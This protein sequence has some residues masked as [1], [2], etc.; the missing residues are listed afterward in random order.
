VTASDTAR[1][2][3]LEFEPGMPILTSNSRLSR[4]PKAAL[5]KD[6]GNRA[7][8][9]AAE[10]RLPCIEYADV[11]VQY[12]PPPRRLRDRHPFASERVEDSGALAPTGKAL[13]DGLTQAGV[14]GANG[15]KSDSRKHVRRELYELLPG[16]HPR[17]Q[18]TVRITEIPREVAR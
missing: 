7:F 18:V 11:L 4:Y 1:T 17:G 8:W 15:K 12:Q 10:A 2:W 16:T 14:F 3:T 9:K 5:I 13:I 6:L